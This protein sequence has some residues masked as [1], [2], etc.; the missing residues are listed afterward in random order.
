MRVVTAA[1]FKLK[2]TGAAFLVV[3]LAAAAI[4]ALFILRHQGD[5]GTLSAVAERAARERFDPELAAG[6]PAPALHGRRHRRVDQRDRP[7]RQDAVSLAAPRG[8]H[9]RSA[10]RVG[11]RFGA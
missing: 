5:V 9:R 6:A 11:H 7:L 1:G 2:Y 10:A 4:V 3:L 8:R